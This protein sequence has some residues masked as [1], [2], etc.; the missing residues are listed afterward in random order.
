MIVYIVAFA[1]VVFLSFVAEKN[2]NNERKIRK[3]FILIY[4]LLSL[5][6]GLRSVS[7]G[8]DTK[9]YLATTYGYL[10]SGYSFSEITSI[11]GLEK[12]YLGLM[13]I[14]HAITN[15]P[16]LGI[17]ILSLLSNLGPLVY[18]Y[19]KRN[20]SSLVVLLSIHYCTL[21]LFTF[22]ILRQ[23]VALSAFF[24]MLLAIK[25]GKKIRAI[26]CF[27]VGF[28]F[29]NS[30][31]FSLIPL[32]YFYVAKSKKI[33]NRTKFLIINEMTLILS[34]MA[35]FA[36]PLLEVLS[37]NG[38][39]GDRYMNYL[40]ES[41]SD[42]KQEI[43]IEYSLLFL[44]TVIMFYIYAYL[45]KKTKMMEKVSSMDY[46]IASA[47]IVDYIIMFLSFKLSNT[48]RI[49]WYIFY[50]AIYSIV[51]KVTIIFSRKNNIGLAEAL[52]VAPFVL[53]LLEKLIT[54]QYLIIPYRL[55]LGMA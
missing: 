6:C 3:I 2:K 38:L 15:N 4:I 13:V 51:P 19:R 33:N 11:Y 46:S 41:S 7:V 48:D 50:P 23:S 28:L 52:V 5:F 17:M 39:L 34:I 27:V 14:T 45:R 10:D 1:L 9:M 12:G 40:D 54:N 8:Y 53:Y 30:M 16:W 32:A 43:N 21:Y 37:N 35:I 44:K 49:T 22:N 29:H 36:F 18:I 31:I 42:F 55:S 26:T 20:K 25:D 24:F 47:M